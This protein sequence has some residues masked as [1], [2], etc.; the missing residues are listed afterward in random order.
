MTDRQILSSK[1]EEAGELLWHTKAGFI[2]GNRQFNFNDEGE[3]KTIREQT[4]VGSRI[5]SRTHAMSE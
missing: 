4:Q 3:L 2:V 5:V 1:L